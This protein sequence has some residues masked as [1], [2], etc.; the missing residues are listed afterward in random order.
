MIK[1]TSHFILSC[2]L[3]SSLFGLSACHHRENSQQIRLGTISGPETE[4]MQVAKQVAQRD[5]GLQIKIIEF[6]DYSIPNR[7][8][9]DGNLDA[10]LFQHQAFLNDEMHNRAYAL[11]PIAKAFIYPMAIYSA[12]IQ[13][14][15]ELKPHAIVAIPNDPS[16]EARALLL[17]SSA[18]L[19]TLDTRKGTFMTPNDIQLNPKHLVIKELDAA[20]LSRVLADVDLA[21][22]NANYAAL[23]HLYP[24]QNALFSESKTSPYANLL[25]VKLSDKNNPKFIN[26]IKAIHSPEV[27][28]AAARLFHDTAIPAWK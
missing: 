6:S 18:G 23:A 16:N 17:L 14:L 9:N 13:H 10:N 7:A 3:L 8:L 24:Q 27:L 19:L 2:L 11:T 28:A 21:V 22:I 15:N 25:V 4:L 26:L 20:Q 1:K 12:K 5:Y